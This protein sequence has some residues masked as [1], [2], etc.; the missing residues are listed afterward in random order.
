MQ[1]YLLVQEKKLLI[2]S[3]AKYFKKNKESEP[4]PAVFATTNPTKV[5]TMKSSSKFYVDFGNKIAKDK[6]ILEYLTDI[7]RI[8]TKIYINLM[9][10]KMRK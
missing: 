1:D 4:E 8:R 5:Q 3:K 7:L 2:I 10:I 6:Q 9:K